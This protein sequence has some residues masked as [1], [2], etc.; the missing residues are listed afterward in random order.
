[1]FINAA[2]I[3]LSATLTVLSAPTQQGTGLN[4]RCFHNGDGSYW[5][6][7]DADAEASSAVARTVKGESDMLVKRCFHNGGGSYW[8]PLDADAEG[9][10]AEARALKEESDMLTKRCFHN[11]DGWYWCPGD[12]D[13]EA[14]APA[15]AS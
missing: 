5:C 2:L 1:M 10:S 9:P 4:E 6:P 14:A 15:T 11:G 12:G 13:T 8:C 7:V 3:V